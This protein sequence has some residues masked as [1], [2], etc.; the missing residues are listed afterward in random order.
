MNKRLNSNFIPAKEFRKRHDIPR[1]VL[2]MHCVNHKHKAYLQ[3]TKDGYLIDETML[4]NLH[5]RK[6]HII[7]TAQSL[8]YKLSER[9][10][11]HQLAIKLQ[12]ATGRSKQSWYMYL[13]YGDMFAISDDSILNTRITTRT[14]LFYN[15]AP[16]ILEN[17]THA[18]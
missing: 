2:S 9:I 17:L 7:E 8:Y 16:H 1:H 14:A 3:H 18:Y 12:Q 4:L 11:N 15:H 10:N 5:E 6:K 13:H